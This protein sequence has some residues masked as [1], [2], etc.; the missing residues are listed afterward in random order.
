MVSI[1]VVSA[2]SPAEAAAGAAAVGR[3]T[4]RDFEEDFRM[5]LAYWNVEQYQASWIRAL[6]VLGSADDAVACLVSSITD[7]VNSNFIFCWPLYRSGHAVHVQNSIILL[8]EIE[9]D[10]DPHEPWRHVEPR[11]TV[12]EDGHEISEWETTVGEV[13]EF[14]RSLRP[15]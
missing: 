1:R 5:D 10:F 11:A 9:E 13:G 8:D 7:P 6:E 2:P 12:D 4:V 14:L 3:I 15:S